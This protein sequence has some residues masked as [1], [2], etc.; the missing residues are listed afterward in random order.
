MPELQKSLVLRHH[1]REA[2]PI[3]RKMEPPLPLSLLSSTV[4]PR[5]IRRDQEG[6]V[7]REE[8]LGGGSGSPSRCLGTQAR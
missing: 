5:A 4:C 6:Q 7:L 2:A 1:F 3:A 8:G